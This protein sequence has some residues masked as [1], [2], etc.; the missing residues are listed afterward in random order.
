MVFHYYPFNVF[1]VSNDVP[2]FSPDM[3]TLCYLYIF[4]DEFG[5]RFINFVDLFK[6]SFLPISLKIFSF[7]KI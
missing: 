3:D 4:F 5:Q 2:S 7:D 6:D 1:S